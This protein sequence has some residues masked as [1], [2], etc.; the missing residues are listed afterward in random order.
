VRCEEATHELDALLD[1]ELAGPEKAALEKH[2]AECASCREELA[3]LERTRERVRALPR[4]AAPA[5]L[6][7]G[8]G[9]LF[10]HAG[11]P[12]ACHSLGTGDLSAYL[13]AELEEPARARVEGH[14]GACFDCRRELV[15]LDSVVASVQAIP[16]LAAPPSLLEHVRERIALLGRPA[17][18]RT[19]APAPEPAAAPRAPREPIRLPVPVKRFLAAASL[20]VLALGALSI[21]T[22]SGEPRLPSVSAPPS[23]VSHPAAFSVAQK[24]VSDKSVE[25]AVLQKPLERERTIVLI[26]DDKVNFDDVLASPQPLAGTERTREPGTLIARGTA[27]EL[28]SLL[29]E[30]LPPWASLEDRSALD[31]LIPP[32]LDR[33]FGRNGEVYTGTIVG[34]DARG[35]SLRSGSL[36]LDLP[37]RSVVRV[38]RASSEPTEIGILFRRRPAA[39]PGER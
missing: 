19:A 26:V 31:A 32:P 21:A 18:L 36:A 24:A 28:R 25:T 38:E 30:R 34:Q 9:A 17:P 20:F 15:A 2:L 29:L 12:S 27:I 37:A 3:S 39:E 33:V 23:W 5:A 22:P 8:V 1:G 16:R 7:E 4:V 35:V 14:L 13:D 11:K 10:A 6:L